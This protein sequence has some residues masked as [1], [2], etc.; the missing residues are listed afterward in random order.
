MK[1]KSSP[2]KSRFL[3]AGL[4]VWAGVLAAVEM[5]YFCW[6]RTTTA[7]VTHHWNERRSG[8]RGHGD[9]SVLVVEFSYPLPG[10]ELRS[11][12][13][14]LVAG[15]PI[16]EGASLPI[17]YLPFDDNFCRPKDGNSRGLHLFMIGIMTTPVVAVYLF[18]KLTA[19]LSSGPLK[20]LPDSWASRISHGALVYRYSGFLGRPIS[21]IVDRTEGLIHFQNC[22]W[23]NK[24]LVVRAEPWFTCSLSEVR[25]AKHELVWE[26][27]LQISTIYGKATIQPEA[28]NFRSLCDELDRCVMAVTATGRTVASECV[29]GDEDSYVLLVSF[30]LAFVGVFA[31]A[32][33]TPKTASIGTVALCMLAGG[34]SCFLLAHFG[35]E[36]V[37]RRLRR[38]IIEPIGLG[39]LAGYAVLTL[40]VQMS[41]QVDHRW[42]GLVPILMGIAG[43]VVGCV[44][45]FRK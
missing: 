23:L 27:P 15:F 21:V 28:T 13:G 16:N 20:E 7:K 45:Q 26:S 10:G 24:F 8:G 32:W 33:F 34:I 1:K 17:E 35:N 9:Y 39:L 5:S 40:V 18:G 6:G 42:L 19:F 38:S 4:M 36:L 29:S 25:A 31:G 22:H 43:V 41:P 14:E 44:R 3:A 11:G 12:R 37:N 30:G 2:F